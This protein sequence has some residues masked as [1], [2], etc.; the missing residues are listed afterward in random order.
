MSSNNTTYSESE[1]VK[2]LIWGSHF[3]YF[4]NNKYE[5]VNFLVHYFKAGLENNE[6][7]IWV[8]SEDLTPDFAINALREAVIDFDDYLKKGQIKI[9]PY[10]KWY[11]KEKVFTLEKV[12]ERATYYLNHALTN[13]Y[14]GLRATGDIRWLDKNDLERF[15]DYEIH[16][17]NIIGDYKMKASCTYP[18]SRF[19]K[20]ELLDIA[21]S[22]QFVLTKSNGSYKIIENIDSERINKEKE[23]IKSNIQKIQYLLN[24]IQGYAEVAMMK[25]KKENP[26][27]K[28]LKK[29]N[30]STESASDLTKKMLSHK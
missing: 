5:L 9:L 6:F 1:I 8:I 14:S 15:I 19:N 11:L 20:F 22:H 24:S 7:C 13:G 29:I 17:N 30:R 4:Y 10:T 16:V 25:I 2:K 28:Y 26:T 18:I 21:N 3:C 23:L 12:I 27:Y